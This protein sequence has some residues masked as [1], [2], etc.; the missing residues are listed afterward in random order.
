MIEPPYRQLTAEQDAVLM[1]PIDTRLIVQGGPGTGKTRMAVYRALLHSAAEDTA[2]VVV[3]GELRRLQMV[4]VLGNRR[5]RIR[6]LT[7]HHLLELMVPEVVA[8]HRPSDEG[9]WVE[10]LIALAKRQTRVVGAGWALVLDDAHDM[11]PGLHPLIAL[12]AQRMAVFHDQSTV[13]SD[14][15]TDEATLTASYPAATHLPLSQGH[16]WTSQ[17]ASL[18]SELMPGR[19]LPG[20]SYVTG[21]GE[22]VLAVQMRSPAEVAVFVAELLRAAP[23]TRIAVACQS[24]QAFR[25]LSAHLRNTVGERRYTPVWPDLA[26]RPSQTA[27][28]RQVLLIRRDLLQGLEFDVIIATEIDNRGQDV[29][30]LDYRGPLYRTIAAA[31]DRVVLTWSGPGGADRLISTLPSV[32]PIASRNRQMPE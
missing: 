32:D 21:S 11:P 18:A 23:R 27:F 30:G 19:R 1:A 10:A 9:F 24:Q 6:V 3:P 7:V 5:S 26:M 12:F 8:N 29:T 13:I 15:Q 25:G 16:R 2:V 14:R 17:I 28:M 20:R 22:P 4:S 31:R